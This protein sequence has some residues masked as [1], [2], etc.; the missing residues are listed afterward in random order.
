MIRF[1]SNGRVR[2]TVCVERQRPEL[3][4]LYE[5]QRVA[6]PVIGLEFNLSLRDPRYVAAAQQ[7]Q[8]RSF[9]IKE[10]DIGVGL[11]LLLEPAATLMY[12]PVETVSE[13]EGGLERTYQA[14][15]VLC[16]WTPD[17]AS[18]WSCRVRW[19]LI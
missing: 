10:E 8:V 3:T 4:C 14:L 7:E 16:W 18:T 1:V 17:G 12:F 19:T 2:K 13:S 11:R 6:V 15:C 9:D 5:L